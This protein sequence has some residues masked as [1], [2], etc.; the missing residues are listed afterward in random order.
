MNENK[1]GTNLLLKI[2]LCENDN[3]CEFDIGLQGVN[4]PRDPN[5]Y[6]SKYFRIYFL[7]S[8]VKKLCPIFILNHSFDVYTATNRNTSIIWKKKYIERIEND[9]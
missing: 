8:A 1:N 2:V 4:F 6:L 7:K 3:L 9:G 5:N